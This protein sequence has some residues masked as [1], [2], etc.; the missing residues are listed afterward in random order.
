MG[1]CIQ[2]KLSDRE[3]LRRSPIFVFAGDP[4]AAGGIQAYGQTSGPSTP[5]RAGR[6]RTRQEFLQLCREIARDAFVD[7]VLLAP[8]DAEQ[9]ALDE[10]LFDAT[11]VTPLVRM[12]AE[13]G[14][15]NPRYGNY[16]TQV[17]RPFQTVPADASW[18]ETLAGTAKR[19]RVQIGL[20]SITLNND[21]LAD[22]TTLNAY[23]H[24]ARELGEH[25]DPQDSASFHHILEVFLPNYERA[26]LDG[27]RAGRYVAD[28]IVR[29]MS[30]LRKS[31]RP[32]FI[33]TEFT[34]AE[35]WRELTS[36]DETLVVGALGGPRQNARRTLELA[37]TVVSNGGRAILFGRAVF[38][39]D[40]PRLICKY[41]RAV[42]DGELDPEAAHQQYQHERRSDQ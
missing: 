8:A 14:I 2:Q 15:W 6:Y 4:I 20:Y 32:L 33:K 40:C 28:S 3:A 24:F 12:N 30:Y 21:V 36:F 37:R 19:C 23:L 16:R 38:E 13:T 9:L 7:G 10:R 25:A 34:T 35:V 18:C 17:S 26:G 5:L 29:T 27:E 31:Q 22:E 41:L 1:H 42:L 39:E 11:A